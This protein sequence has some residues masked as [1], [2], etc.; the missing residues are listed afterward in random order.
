MAH[1]ISYRQKPWLAHYEKG[2]PE[3]LTYDEA[4][5][6]EFLERSARQFP[7][8]TALYFQGYR[9]SYRQLNDMTSRFA[10]CLDQLGIQRNIEV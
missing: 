8:T 3:H 6:P 2:V 10:A 5:L 1:E 7:E 4:C 9:V